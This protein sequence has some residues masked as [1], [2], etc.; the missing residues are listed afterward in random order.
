MDVFF[1]YLWQLGPYEAV[2]VAGFICYIGAFGAVQLDLMDGNQTHFTLLNIL[3]A[4]LVGISL[5]AEFNLASALIQGSW[6]FIGLI[7]LC[8]RLYRSIPARQPSAPTTTI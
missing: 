6:I 1:Q 5:I 7:G 3:A 4:C 8:L 2:G